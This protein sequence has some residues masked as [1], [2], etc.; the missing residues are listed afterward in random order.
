M[1]PITAAVIL[2]LATRATSPAQPAP[3]PILDVHLHAHRA[4]VNGP[5]PTAVCPGI[6]EWTELDPKVGWP[7]AFG[8]LLKNPPCKDPIWG[9]ATDEDLMRQTIEVLERRNITA[10]TSGPLLEQW[11]KAGGNRIIPALGF[12]FS[13]KP[14]PTPAQ[15]RQWF[16]QK[17]YAVFAEVGIQYDGLSPSDPKFEPYLAVAE[18]LD[19]PV[20]IH[21]GTGPPG[22]VYLGFSGYRARLHSPLLIEDALVRH[23]KL[24]VYIMHAGWPMLD[25]LLAVLWAHP[26]VHLDVGAIA[27]ALPRKEFHRYLQRIVEAGF[28][29]RVMFGSDQMNWPKAI[30]VSI[31]AIET[32]PFLTANQKRA[33]LYD[34]AARFL[35][36]SATAPAEDRAAAP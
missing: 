7:T 16:S 4:G 17:R 31:D 30:E 6:A 9:P 21:I 18:S 36:L 12:A 1:K 10:V 19:V 22:A 25:D 20:G 5:P 15:V 11:R 14:V 24:R 23:P 3:P 32:A 33:I 8:S 28:G 35:R 2:A 34:N 27:F 26:Q 29:S 13:Q